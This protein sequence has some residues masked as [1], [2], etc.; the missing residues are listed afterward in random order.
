M[1][2]QMLN[3]GFKITLCLSLLQFYKDFIKMT[4]FLYFFLNKKYFKMADKCVWLCTKVNQNP[5]WTC[6]IWNDWKECVHSSMQLVFSYIWFWFAIRQDTFTEHEVS[7][8]PSFHRPITPL[9]KNSFVVFWLWYYHI[10]ISVS[11]HYFPHMPLLILAVN[12]SIWRIRIIPR[13]ISVVI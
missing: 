1:V 13:R 7:L 2:F 12:F 3:P 10:W 4:L 6:Y 11:F 8:V 5:A 9:Q